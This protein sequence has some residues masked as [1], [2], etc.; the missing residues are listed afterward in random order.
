MDLID[1]TSIASI[2]LLLMVSINTLINITRTIYHF[3]VGKKLN[4][5]KDKTND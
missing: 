5:K 1:V 2:W 3:Y 4:S